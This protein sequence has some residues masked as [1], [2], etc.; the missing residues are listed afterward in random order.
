MS[1]NSVMMQA[2]E[3]YLDNDGTIKRKNGKDSLQELAIKEILEFDSLK[4]LQKYLEKQ[5]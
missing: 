4:E 3:W 2:F 5:N 1:E